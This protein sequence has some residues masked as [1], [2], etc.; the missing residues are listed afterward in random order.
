MSQ[1]GRVK[2]RYC[3]KDVGVKTFACPYKYCGPV[4]MCVACALSHP[5]Q[6]TKSGH[7][8]KGCEASATAERTRRIERHSLAEAG[9]F[10]LASAVVVQG[11]MAH[12]IFRA[13]LEKK[14]KFVPLPIYEKLAANCPTL[15]DVERLAGMPLPDAPDDFD[16]S[17]LPEALATAAAAFRQTP[18]RTAPAEP[19]AAQPSLFLT[20]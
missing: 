1:A 15:A 13:G 18:G 19:A 4:A 3:Q 12:A 10:I 6:K 2:C 8:A 5:E 9:H 17:Y 7:R 16:S 20:A 14:G 11:G